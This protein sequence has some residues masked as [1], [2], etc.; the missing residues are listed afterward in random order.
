[1]V[2]TPIAS[3]AQEGE[4]NFLITN[5]S[6]GERAPFEGILLT[7]ESLAKIEADLK[8]KTRLCENNCKLEVEKMQLLHLRDL[9]LLNSELHGLNKILT[10]KDSRIKELEQIVEDANDSW[11]VPIVGIAS[12]ILGVTITVGITYAVNK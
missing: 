9:G 4:S 6:K 11:A 5:L 2:L 10:V 1:M 3:F 7:Q 8:L 12:F